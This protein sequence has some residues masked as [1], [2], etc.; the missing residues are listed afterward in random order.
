MQTVIQVLCKKGKS[1]REVITKDQQIE[2][3]PYRLKRKKCKSPSRPNGWTE[4][5]SLDRSPGALKIEW[6]A[7]AQ[8]LICRVI[9]KLGNSPS[10]IVGNFVSY[11]VARHS[12]RFVTI[13]IS[14]IR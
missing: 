9:T 8:T 4:V 12:K 14:T 2:N 5:S 10:S 7:S 13:I 11:L 3:E 1:L 6:D